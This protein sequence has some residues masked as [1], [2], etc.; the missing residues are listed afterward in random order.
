LLDP[1]GAPSFDELKA[2]AQRVTIERVDLMIASLDHLIA[3]KRRAGRPKDMLALSELV[4]I[5]DAIDREQGR[6]AP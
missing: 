2:T 6:S 3:L 1:A 4:E 5:A